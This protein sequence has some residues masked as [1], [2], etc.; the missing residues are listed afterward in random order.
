MPEKK[1]LA[2]LSERV[3]SELRRL[4]REEPS[5][6]TDEDWPSADR[7]TTL[8]LND[9]G[10]RRFFNRVVA[11]YRLNQN[12]SRRV[13]GKLRKALTRKA[14]QVLRWEAALSELNE[15]DFIEPR[16]NVSPGKT[17]DKKRTNARRQITAIRNSLKNLAKDLE[18][19]KEQLPQ[20]VRWTPKKIEVLY[21]LI[22]FLHAYLRELTGKGLS[23][24]KSVEAGARRKLVVW[25][26]KIADADLKE[27]TILTAMQKAITKPMKAAEQKA[28]KKPMKAAKHLA[29]IDMSLGSI[30]RE[31]VE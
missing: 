28:I 26:F 30:F 14:E 8:D 23:R 31:F 1:P 25:L 2:Y 20:A 24:G 7:P 29:I 16:A 11:F 21:H 12:D 15:A 27:K 9:P 19:T 18:R 13:S 6:I 22:Y 10:D 4:P 5:I 17:L 3:A